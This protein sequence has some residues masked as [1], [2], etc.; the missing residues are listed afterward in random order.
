[1][2]NAF[3]QIM[4]KLAQKLCT[5]GPKSWRRPEGSVL[6]DLRGVP[7]SPAHGKSAAP[8]ACVAQAL[9]EIQNADAARLYGL[10]AVW[11][12]VGQKLLD[13]GC[14]HRIGRL[15]GRLLGRIG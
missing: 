1:M 11:K 8:N 10:H 6:N 3:S 4:E 13:G 9:W 2:E 14:K 15:K 7:P 5:S 12:D